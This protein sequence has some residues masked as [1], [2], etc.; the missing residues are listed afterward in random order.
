[1]IEPRILYEDED[2]CVIDKPSGM[3]VN[4]SNS[5]HEITIQEWF[6]NKLEYKELNTEFIQ[7]GGV[8][9]RLDKDASGALILAKN[10]SAYEGLKK[11]FM[12]RETEKIYLVM[13][14][15]QMK[16]KEGIIATPV[17][18]NPNKKMRFF[19]GTDLSKTGITSWKV[20]AQNIDYSFLEVKIMTGRTHQIRVHMKHLGHPVVADPLYGFAKRWQGDLEFC[21][22]LFLH[23][24]KLSL[25]HPVNLKWLTFTAELPEELRKTYEKC[26]R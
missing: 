24:Y 22:R 21:P 1:M 2:I 11:Q 26:F 17:E 20:L 6:E 13:V 18:R 16:E 9:H 8:V 5:T 12:N 25:V 7:K 14:H 23:A 4:K 10:D 3:V 19:V 15:G